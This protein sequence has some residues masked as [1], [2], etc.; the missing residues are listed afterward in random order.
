MPRTRGTARIRHV[1]CEW[2]RY[3]QKSRDE[4]RISAVRA[5]EEVQDGVREVRLEFCVSRFRP[6]GFKVQDSKTIQASM[7][8]WTVVPGRSKYIGAVRFFA[9]KTLGFDLVGWKVGSLATSRFGVKAKGRD[10]P[11]GGGG[12]RREISRGA[13]KL[14]D[15]LPSFAVHTWTDL[16]WKDSST[17][18][19]PDTDSPR[20]G[21]GRSKSNGPLCPQGQ[22][23]PA[24]TLARA[25]VSA[26]HF[27]SG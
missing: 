18:D 2:Q 19:Y 20:S 10:V 26:G 27:G 22:R 3:R 8:F 1:G 12:Q 7:Q 4:W 5:R 14:T 25:K 6:G 16:P 11:W 9:T 15:L 13:G 21:C 23:C 24:D 17:N